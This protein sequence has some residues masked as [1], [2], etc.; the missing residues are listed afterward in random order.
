[1]NGGVDEHGRQAAAGASFI[2]SSDPVT[3]HRIVFG[4]FNDL[5]FN[6][7]LRD[8]AKATAMINLI[9]SADCETRDSLILE[10]NEPALDHMFVSESLV[11]RVE[12]FERVH[13]NAEFDDGASD[14]DAIV[15]SLDF[16]AGV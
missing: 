14:H 12:P 8:F 15:A 1:M 7:V 13:A 16:A 6:A 3:M 2:A 9:W 4:D 5:V 10:G 11:W